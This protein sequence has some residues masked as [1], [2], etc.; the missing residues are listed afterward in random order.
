MYVYISKISGKYIFF[1]E[2]KRNATVDRLLYFQKSNTNSS[3]N[4]KNVF[5]ITSWFGKRNREIIFMFWKHPINIRL[6]KT[7]KIFL[8]SAHIL[9]HFHVY[10]ILCDI[11][12]NVGGVLN[13]S[14]KC[15]I[16]TKT[17][18]PWFSGNVQ[19]G[20]GGTPLH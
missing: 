7:L 15:V 8:S 4:S 18:V 10:H 16:F 2:K 17:W 12:P 1:L 6:Q 14:C 3:K 13:R 9:L 11:T 20:P 19:I 5:F